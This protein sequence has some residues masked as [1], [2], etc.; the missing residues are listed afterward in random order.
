[1]PR[2]DFYLLPEHDSAERFTCKLA[3]KIR[4]QSL[5]IHIHTGSREAA[6]AMDE[7]LWTFKDISFLPHTLVD[8][9]DA[10]DNPITI[11]WCGTTPLTNEVLINLSPEVPEF[12]QNF[13]R[14]IEIVPAQDTMRSQARERYRQYREQGFEL[15]SHDLESS[16]ADRQ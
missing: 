6:Q 1:M 8:E 11:G 10:A 14:I 3:D 13:A 15:H 5:H 4:R 9:R 16:H 2:A 7:L 12:T